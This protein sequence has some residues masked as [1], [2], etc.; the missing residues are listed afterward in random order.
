MFTQ[1]AHTVV[2]IIHKDVFIV[3]SQILLLSQ[4]LGLIYLLPS[5]LLF[6]IIVH[7][8]LKYNTLIL[9]ST[10]LQ[11]RSLLYGDAGKYFIALY[12]LNWTNWYL[13]DINSAHGPTVWHLSKLNAIKCW[14]NLMQITLYQCKDIRSSLAL[15]GSLIWYRVKAC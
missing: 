6:Q 12:R 15:W 8:G 2:T 10:C 9:E 5:L 4:N 13:F 11:F 14:R 1:T 7:F 3:V